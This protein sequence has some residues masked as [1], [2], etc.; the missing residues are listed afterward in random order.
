MSIEIKKTHLTRFLDRNGIA[1]N[2][3]VEEQKRRTD[4][5]EILSTYHQLLAE[6]PSHRGALDRFYRKGQLSSDVP[7]DLKARSDAIFCRFQ[8]FAAQ[9]SQTTGKTN[10]EISQWLKIHEGAMAHMQIRAT[11]D[12]I[13]RTNKKLTPL[14][15]EWGALQPEDTDDIEN[16][17]QD[18]TTVPETQAAVDPVLK[19]KLER[20]DAEIDALEKLYAFQCQK[21]ASLTSDAAMKDF[22]KKKHFSGPAQQIA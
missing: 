4:F 1:P 16:E 12:G 9:F 15:E 22:L 14:Y 6:Y 7:P 20:I 18:E 21:L 8:T 5:S 13:E 3:A 17:D 11:V 2:E 10:A 19:A